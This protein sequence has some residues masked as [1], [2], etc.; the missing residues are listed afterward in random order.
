MVHCWE[1]PITLL[2]SKPVEYGHL[3]FF[4][5]NCQ[6][7]I[8]NLSVWQETQWGAPSDWFFI[9]GSE[10][11]LKMKSSINLGW[12]LSPVKKKIWSCL[13]KNVSSYP[14]VVDILVVSL[15]YNDKSDA[16]R[17]LIPLIVKQPSKSSEE[18]KIQSRR[19]ERRHT[20]VKI[21]II[22]LWKTC[23]SWECPRNI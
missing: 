23:G 15:L 7:W 22:I 5:H 10:L 16:D 13:R 11:L 4:L 20:S 14:S 1:Q 12:S 3:K 8:D 9:F 21:I 6:A 2:Q 17:V 18:K 19:W